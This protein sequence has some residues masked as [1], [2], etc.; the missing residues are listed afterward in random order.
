M[1]FWSLLIL[2]VVVFTGLVTVLRMMIRRNMTD[3]TARL[4]DLTAEYSRRQEELKQRLGETERQYHDQLNRAK[5]EAERMLKE[6]KEEAESTKTKLLDEARRESERVV[7]LGLE[8]RDSLR[9]ELERGMEKRAVEHACR[10]IEEAL[11][12]DFRQDLQGRWLEDL[13]R[14]GLAQ[15]EQLKQGGEVHE[16]RVV[17]ALP[18]TKEQ[19]DVLRTRLK[20]RLGREVTVQEAVD[21]HLV[22]GLMISV[23]SLV[24]DGSLASKIR[25]SVR[26]AHDA[27]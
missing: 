2:Q 12:P 1:S 11:P 9:K 21:E 25:T 5:T 16:V 20:D 6:A 4:Q 10:L 23:G 27:A 24:F 15:L 19:R 22:V 17:S 8:T 26:H 18:L 7:Q 3:A 14:N 13:F